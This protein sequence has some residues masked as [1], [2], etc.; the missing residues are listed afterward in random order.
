MARQHLET[1]AARTEVVN[2]V[3][4]VAQVAPRDPSAFDTSI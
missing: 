1:N 3:D 2:D 4:E